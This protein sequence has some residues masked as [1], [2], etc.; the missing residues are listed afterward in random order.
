MAD[1]EQKKQQGGDKQKQQHQQKG[2]GAPKVETAITPTRAQDY[3][4]WYQ[5]VIRAATAKKRMVSAIVLDD[6]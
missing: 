4:E 1:G 2:G 6:K 5:Q 3:A